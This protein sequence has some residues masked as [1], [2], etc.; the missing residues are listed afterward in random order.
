MFAFHIVMGAMGALY[1]LRKHAPA[2]APEPDMELIDDDIEI[3]A[4]SIH[5]ARTTR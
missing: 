2:P 4:P 1:Y 3:P 5:A